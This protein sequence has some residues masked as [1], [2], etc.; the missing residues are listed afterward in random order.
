[1]FYIKIFA[2][3]FTM[4]LLLVTLSPMQSIGATLPEDGDAPHLSLFLPD[5]YKQND[6]VLTL[7]ST[8]PELVRARNQCF[9]HVY[10]P[11]S[12]IY[13]TRF[14]GAIDT[15]PTVLLQDKEGVIAYKNSHI[16]SLSE[17]KSSF[18][19]MFNKKPWLRAR[20][21]LRPK[22]SP[23]PGPDC[24]PDTKP[25]IDIDIDRRPTLIPDTVVPQEEF[26]WLLLGVVVAAAGGLA[27]YVNWRKR[28]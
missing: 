25:N 23:C 24:K 7:F 21:W 15:T 20:P 9:F 16:N 10:T 4:L 19:V 5:N 13:R 1:M 11:S 17:L 18:L 3:I 26:P 22:P 28:T 14:E 8:D 12:T 6:P 2:K 27:L